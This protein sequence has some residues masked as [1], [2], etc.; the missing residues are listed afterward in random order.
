MTV[1]IPLESYGS[2]FFYLWLRKQGKWFPV[3]Q[4]LRTDSTWTEQDKCAGP[5]NDIKVIRSSETKTSDLSVHIKPHRYY[6]TQP[7]MFKLV[8]H[9][10]EWGLLKVPDSVVFTEVL[11]L[12]R[13]STCDS[14]RTVTNTN[15]RPL[16]YLSM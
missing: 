15:E 9:Y 1:R 12:G 10:G 3:V 13:C 8:D 2:A 14:S 7:P 4:R 6:R 5:Y 16:V 11:G